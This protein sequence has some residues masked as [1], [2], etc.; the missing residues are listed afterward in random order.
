V[1]TALYY[2]DNMSV[3]ATTAKHSFCMRDTAC[4]RAGARRR[5]TCDDQGI[6]AG[7][8]DTYSVAVPCQW[9]VVDGLPLDR[10]YVL[11]VAVDP[12]DFVAESDDANNVAE[13]RFRLGDVRSDGGA[14]APAWMLLLLLWVVPMVASECWC[15]WRCGRPR[16]RE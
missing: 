1:H 11:R 4:T 6:T 16:R 10:E 12:T 5:F 8:H 14:L 2:A 3:A 13:L 7:C 15:T 9:L